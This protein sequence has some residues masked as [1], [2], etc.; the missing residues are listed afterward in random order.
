M[1]A[2]TIGRA[3]R[4]AGV[5]IET[6]RFYE[7]RGL[8]EQPPKGEGYRIYSSEQVARIRFVK[9]A[10]QIGFSLTEI[11]ELLTLRADPAADCS[12]VRQQAIAKREEVRRKIERLQQIDAALE[13]LVAAC[14]GSGALEACSIM[15]ALSFRSSKPTGPKKTRRFRPESPAQRSTR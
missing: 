12:Y 2:L 7:R 15:D 4:E 11:G 1:Q 6:V 3:A 14:P 5:N 10:Q 9:E 8:I 13:T